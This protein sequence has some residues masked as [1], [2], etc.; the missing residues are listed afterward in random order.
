MKTAYGGD[1]SVARGDVGPSFNITVSNGIIL[2][3]LDALT[4]A[5]KV[6]NIQAGN[7]CGPG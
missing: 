3:Q 1:V 6:K 7:Y 4:D 2:G 5:G